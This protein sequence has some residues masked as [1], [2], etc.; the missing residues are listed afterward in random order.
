M[1]I[2]DTGS[3]KHAVSEQDALKALLLIW[4][5]AAQKLP[6]EQRR[7]YLNEQFQ[8]LPE[9][10]HSSWHIPEDVFDKVFADTSHLLAGDLLETAEIS[11]KGNAFLDKVNAALDA[12]K[13]V[14]ESTE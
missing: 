10:Y 2:A 4:I 13:A 6:K 11:D 8:L 1:S 9:P 7:A 3:R 12:E 14:A 5:Q